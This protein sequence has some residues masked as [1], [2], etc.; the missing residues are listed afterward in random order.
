MHSLCLLLLGCVWLPCSAAAA[1]AQPDA[2]RAFGY[3]TQIC[4]IG[5][6]ISG[7]PGMTR[8]QQLIAKHCANFDC[9]VKFQPFDA[10]HPLTGAAVRMNNIIVSWH[11]ETKRRVLLCCHY[12]TRPLPDR[13]RNQF[14]RERGTFLGGNDGASG[15]ALFMELAHHMD[16][17]RPEFGVDFVFFDGEE[18]IYGP[19]GE[20]FLGSKFFAKS[21]RDEPPE[22]RYEYGIL[23]DMIGDR[24][25]R[26]YM[27]KKSLHYAPELTKSIWDSAKQLK[28]REFVPRLKHDVRDDHLPLNEIARIPTCDIIDFDY[29]HWHTTRDLPNACSGESLVKVASVLL[30]WL[31][32]P[33]PVRE[34]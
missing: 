34:R 27:E 17:I 11:P 21:Y 9:E 28:I 8:Q 25:L 22:H 29:P 31:Q 32:S 1:E 20:Y 19:R 6:R 12:D 14:Q 13:D 2:K 26:I 18:L 10:T 23:V 5:T 30:H 24:N 7:S 4:R 16:S 33:L 3:L 15:V